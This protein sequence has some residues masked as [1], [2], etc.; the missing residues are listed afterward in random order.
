MELVPNF[1]KDL[2]I[3]IG[4]TRENDLGTVG[5]PAM[6]LFLIYLTNSRDYVKV[7]EPPHHRDFD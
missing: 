3:A 5:A 1:H 2:R 7:E 4:V 6:T